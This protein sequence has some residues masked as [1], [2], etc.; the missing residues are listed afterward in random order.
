MNSLRRKHGQ[1]SSN[2]TPVIYESAIREILDVI[3][4][5]LKTYNTE[6]HGFA[7]GENL[8]F[9]AGMHHSE[10]SNMGTDNCGEG[11]WFDKTIF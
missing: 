9:V 5:E 10:D 11:F 2:G 8:S 4:T 1:V 7:K 6:H 3:G